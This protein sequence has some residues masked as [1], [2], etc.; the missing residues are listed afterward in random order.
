MSSVA[1]IIELLSFLTYNHRV[2]FV[3]RQDS[4]RCF[5]RENLTDLE[6]T[7]LG[8]MLRAANVAPLSEVLYRLTDDEKK[9]IAER[10]KKILEEH[11]ELDFAIATACATNNKGLK[12]AIIN[13]LITF[14]ESEALSLL[15]QNNFNEI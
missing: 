14:I 11:D 7:P 13:Q 2:I 10:T 15:N 4:R 8:S 9:E 3:S 1:E 12:D 5:V 6:N